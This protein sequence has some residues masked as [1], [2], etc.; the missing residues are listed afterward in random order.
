[1]HPQIDLR[2]HASDD[3]VDGRASGVDI[4]N[5]Y[6]RGPYPG[7][8]S[9]ALIAD[10]FAPVVNPARRLRSP[11]DI[12]DIPFI[13][14]EW[15]HA[16]PDHPTWSSWF[17]AAGIAGINPVSVLRFFD[18]SHAIQAAWRAKASPFSASRL[19]R[20]SLIGAF[21]SSPLVPSSK[22]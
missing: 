7:L 22:A 19:S 9:T 11:E 2:L 8:A 21:W 3:A 15:K 10:R 1:M 20:T 16:D 14:F 12:L 4:A 18:E 6:G 13:Y 5:R 17:R